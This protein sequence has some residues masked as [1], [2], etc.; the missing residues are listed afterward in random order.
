MVKR[1]EFVSRYADVN[2]RSVLN[3]DVLEL[4]KYVDTELVKTVNIISMINQD[5]LELST[6]VIV[7]SY[8][9]N[10]A[11]HNDN[12]VLDQGN[13]RS[14]GTNDVEF[15]IWGN[16]ITDSDNQTAILTPW[17]NK[18][19]DSDVDGALEIFLPAYTNK[20]AARLLV[21][22]YL[23]PESTDNLTTTDYTDVYGFWRK[24]PQLD[25]SYA[26]D[27]STV[28]LV[29]DVIEHR[30]KIIFKLH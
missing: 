29:W 15:A 24:I 4:E 10:D 11:I 23:G 1:E 22:K 6:D 5:Q 17:Y 21:D 26:D 30:F 19:L 2:K 20:N 16:T 14:G 28:Q 12:T 3:R 8:I 9:T 18:R 13:G 25:G 7:D 27:P